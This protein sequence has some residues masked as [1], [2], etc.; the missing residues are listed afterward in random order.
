M[1]TP[2][3]PFHAALQ[4]ALG[5]RRR[6][7]LPRLPGLHRAAVLVPLTMAE[8]P[9]LLFV[10][11]PQSSRTHA[12]Q[13][14]LPGGRV[15]GQDLDVTAAALRE[16]HEEV[17]MPPAEVQVLGELDDLPTIS[18]RYVITPVVGAVPRIE[19]QP[20]SGEIERAFYVPARALFEEDRWERRP[21]GVGPVRFP[22]SYFRYQDELIWGATAAILE[23]LVGVLEGL[24]G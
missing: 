5:D 17:G 12:G 3:M 24:P 22:V 13:V 6:R 18:S 15:D 10:V 8:E 14:A 11:R 2:P 19:P 9:E 7:S 21:W 20:R 4:A 23:Q 1:T 16:A